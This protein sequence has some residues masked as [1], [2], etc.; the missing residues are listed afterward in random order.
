MGGPAS[1]ISGG[2]GS[3]AV[4]TDTHVHASCRTQLEPSHASHCVF[5]RSGVDTFESSSCSQPRFWPSD[6]S[7][8]AFHAFSPLKAIQRSERRTDRQHGR[9]L[10]SYPLMS[11]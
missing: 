7:D 5:E 4:S 10:T 3:C 11:R 1:S 6:A 8:W 2:G 9:P